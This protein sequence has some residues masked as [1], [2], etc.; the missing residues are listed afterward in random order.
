M[1][2]TQRAKRIKPSPTLAI[3]A[4]A[5]QLKA[6]GQD[7]IG[8]GAGEPDFDT[9]E[10]IKEAAIKAI[11]DGMTKYTAVG[12]I[13]ELKNA[14]IEKFKKDNGLEF[15]ANE[16][17]VS[18]GAKYSL[19]LAMQALLEKDDVMIIP[20]PYWVSYSAQAE[21]ADGGFRLINT[22][23][24]TGFKI[25]GSE[26]EAVIADIKKDGKNPKAFLINSPSNP[27]GA[28]YEDE[29]LIELAN[30]LHKNNIWVI[31]DEIYEFLVYDGY[32]HNSIL[33]LAP[34]IRPHTI[35]INGVSKTYSMTGWRIGYAGGPAD[36]I[37]AMTNIQSQSTSNPTSISQAAALAALTGPQECVEE[38]RVQFDK[39]RK[40]IVDRLNAIDGIS[41]YSPKG[42]FY[43]FPNISG[44]FGKKFEGKAINSG[45]DFADYLL[46]TV[47]V[48]V[49]PG[50]GFGND[51]F[52]RM[53]YATSM[54]DI[55]KGLDRIEEAVNKLS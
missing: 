26:L 31:T 44:V 50:V 24:K 47:K 12:G 40:Y 43:V 52:V 45:S 5:K 41:C 7:V 2:L 29:E 22:T 16:I 14:I 9:P 39:R 1:S 11:Q 8:F 17:L 37:K 3:S 36:V 34:E 54:E 33:A 46:D 51:D 19:Y 55:E 38:M 28:A 15:A 48:A 6:E 4:K 35:V 32:K 20:A 42:A 23:E 21:L 30:I 49:V 18:P 10:F 53:S 25:T 27:T 13:P